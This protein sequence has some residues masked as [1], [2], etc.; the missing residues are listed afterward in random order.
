VNRGNAVWRVS[1]QGYYM[2]DKPI[3]RSDPT[4]GNTLYLTIDSR[5]QYIAETAMRNAA[6]DAAR[7]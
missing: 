3:T 2:G 4:M 6:W 1:S 5:A 7:W